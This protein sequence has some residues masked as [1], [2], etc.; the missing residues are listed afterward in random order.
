MIYKKNKMKQLKNIFRS[1]FIH[2]EAF[3]IGS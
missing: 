1:I 2:N 3:L